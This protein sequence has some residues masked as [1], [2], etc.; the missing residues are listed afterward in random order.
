MPTI[1]RLASSIRFLSCL[2]LLAMAAD[3][4]KTSA[5]TATPSVFDSQHCNNYSAISPDGKY[6]AYQ[7]LPWN[8]PKR[9]W[10]LCDTVT[11]KVLH[12][13]PV[14]GAQGAAFTPDSSRFVAIATRQN[15]KDPNGSPY[16]VEVYDVKTGKQ[17]RVIALKAGQP[18]GG[19]DGSGGWRPSV[20]DDLLVVSGT[21]EVATV[22][23]LN[24]GKVLG[25]LPGKHQAHCM[26]LSR[27]GR[28]LITSEVKP[29]RTPGERP[30]TPHT[31]VV[32]T[33]DVKARKY[34][35]LLYEDAGLIE[36]IAIS[37]DGRWCAVGT[38]WGVKVFDRTTG[39]EKAVCPTGRPWV[40][41]VAFSPDGKQV[42]FSNGG[43]PGTPE[44]RDWGIRFWD[45]QTNA[46]PRLVVSPWTEE[47]KKAWDRR[48]RF[49]IE[50][51]KVNKAWQG[52]GQF[53][54]GVMSDDGTRFFSV[55][56]NQGR[57]LLDLKNPDPKP[58][59]KPEEPKAKK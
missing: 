53:H 27:D 38:H 37:H 57:L 18:G 11:K 31:E 16:Q 40:K 34:G 20:T 13:L 26:A 35:R 30:G 54:A 15:V 10:H 6:V 32:H 46:Q 56:G 14:L 58:E 8:A 51:L 36:A 2:A 43:G 48:G 55:N 24:T 9:P 25:D 59:K 29:P 39:G 28:W 45:W 17:L 50:L 44:D 12:A 23:D 49:H 1:H 4:K 5:I 21:G 41:A 42:I 22:Y 47:E 19:C 7:P 52:K 3:D 33:W